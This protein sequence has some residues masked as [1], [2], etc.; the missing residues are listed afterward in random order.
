MSLRSS[1][2]KLYNNNSN[3]IIRDSAGLHSKNLPQLN[4]ADETNHFADE[5]AK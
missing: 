3:H 1:L 5:L 2:E 4:S